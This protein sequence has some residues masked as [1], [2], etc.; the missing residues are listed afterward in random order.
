MI[1]PKEFRA[2]WY[3]YKPHT[4]LTLHISCTPCQQWVHITPQCCHAW[5]NFMRQIP[6][7]K[8]WFGSGSSYVTIGLAGANGRPLFFG[9]SQTLSLPV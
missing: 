8:D 1:F 3:G 4:T 6:Y 7:Q 2:L 9:H 5:V